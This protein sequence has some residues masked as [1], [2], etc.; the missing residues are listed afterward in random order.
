ME[1]ER[2]KEQELA[3]DQLRLA[4]LQAKFDQSLEALWDTGSGISQGTDSIW[5]AP[6]LSI[7]SGPLWP[8]DNVDATFSVIK[9]DKI[10]E[11]TQIYQES[12][13]NDSPLIPW[14]VDLF[15]IEDY[16][17]ESRTKDS[18]TGKLGPFHYLNR[19]SVVKFNIAK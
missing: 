17:D 4:Q 19:M 7:P 2:E 15:S 3:L 1:R 8:T 13:I 9:D 14:D 10:T 18:K 11:D 6:S 16:A 5:A 12:H